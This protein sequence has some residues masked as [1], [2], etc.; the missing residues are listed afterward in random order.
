MARRMMAAICACFARR[1]LV[2]AVRT[3]GG[4]RAGMFDARYRQRRIQKR[5]RMRHRLGRNKRRDQNRHEGAKQG[6]DHPDHDAQ[7]SH[8]S[9]ADKLMR[10]GW[11]RRDPKLCLSATSDLPSA[12]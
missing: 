10:D 2:A 5:C 11:R 12:V 6:A 9:N 4:F 3:A 7:V 1:M 8:L